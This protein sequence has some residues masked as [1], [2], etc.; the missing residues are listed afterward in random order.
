MV[1]NY[2]LNDNWLKWLKDGLE[3]AATDV[4]NGAMTLT[5]KV[6]K[7]GVRPEK[8]NHINI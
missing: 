5:T 3:L 8:T 6:V 1:R 2:I 4:K 7:L